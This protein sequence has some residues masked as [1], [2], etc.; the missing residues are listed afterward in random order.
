MRTGTRV[1]WWLRGA[2]K[3]APFVI[4]AVIG[5]AGLGVGAAALT[6]GTDISQSSATSPA[7]VTTTSTE[8][9]RAKPVVTTAKARTTRRPS[10]RVVIVATVLH[11]A[12]SPAAQ[13]RQRARLS[14]EMRVTNRHTSAITLARPQ[15]EV[16]GRRIGADRN[17]EEVS[18]G[19]LREFAPG[20]SRRGVLRFETSGST[21]AVLS[22]TRRTTLR[23]AGRTIALQIA[24]GKAA[25]PAR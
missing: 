1:G 2:L 6:S 20:A 24:V 5:G 25:R 4:V 13:A 19:L 9:T 16:D 23:I 3:L 15:I 22:S 21:S 10:M 18:G 11:P 12:A 17:A 8:S 7:R 14:V